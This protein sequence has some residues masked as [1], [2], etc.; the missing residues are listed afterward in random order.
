MINVSF[1]TKYLYFPR[2]WIHNLPVSLKI[3]ITSL[4]FLILPLASN[5]K[6]LIFT[7][8]ILIIQ[9]FSGG[10]DSV[11]IKIL[12]LI[13]LC[14]LLTVI[15]INTDEV[16]KKNIY[17]TIYAKSKISNF[18]LKLILK[19]SPNIAY[20]LLVILPYFSIRSLCIIVDY[21]IIH[22]LLEFSTR[23]EDILLYNTSYLSIFGFNKAIFGEVEFIT[24]LSYYFI[25]NIEELIKNITIAIYIRGFKITSFYYRIQRIYLI[26]LTLY[27][28]LISIMEKI[29][30]CTRTIYS[31]EVK[32][33][34]QQ[35]WLRI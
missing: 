9:L 4:I 30:L 14:L 21:Y 10:L 16:S 27:L 29:M 17:I 33:Q 6:L 35:H 8:Y 28:L 32:I 13:T 24:V 18:I 20:S 5:I 2:S 25:D 23:Y 31:K 1:F 11:S 3:F 26:L 19:G 12:K 15:T 7:C 22:K 34:Y